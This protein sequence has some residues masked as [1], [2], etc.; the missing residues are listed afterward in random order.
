MDQR[1]GLMVEFPWMCEVL[2][3]IAAQ[4]IS[5][6]HTKSDKESEREEFK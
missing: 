3:M 6:T 1:N 2:D 4:H 5:S